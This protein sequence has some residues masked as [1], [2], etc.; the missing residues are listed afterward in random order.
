MRIL[1]SALLLLLLLSLTR[2]AAQN[3]KT[4]NAFAARLNLIDYGWLHDHNVRLGE[5]F[6]L[7]YY[8]NIAP[9]INVGLPLKL[10]L[11]RLPR[12]DNHT[13]TLSVDAIL[14]IQ[15]GSITARVLP[16]IYGGGSYFVESLNQSYVMLPL[17]AGFDIRVSKYAYLSLQG[18]Y[19]DTGVKD[20]DFVQG[21]AGFFFILHDPR[22]KRK[23]LRDSDRDGTPDVLDPCPTEAGPTAALGCPDVDNDS[24]ADRDDLCKT[25]AGPRA[26][27]GCP[28]SDGDGVADKQDDCP[29]L[30]GPLHGCPDSD[31]DGISDQKDKCPQESGPVANQGCPTD[32]D[33]D[34]DGLPDKQDRCPEL[35]GAPALRGCPDSDGDGVPNIDDDCPQQAGAV[36][37]CPDLDNDGVADRDDKCPS[38]AGPA[39]NQG[40]PEVKQETKE[41]LAYATKAV[42]FQTARATLKR[43]SFAIL[44]E[45]AGILQQYPDYKLVIS[46]HTDNVGDEQRNLELSQARAKACHDYLVSKGVAA[47]RLRY[48]GY[49]ETR[50]VGDNATAAGRELNRRVDFELVL[51]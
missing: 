20:R 37:G 7:A 9:W 24:I 23:R 33:S 38:S 44:D 31:G 18:E 12:T 30:A 8:R 14:K 27:G 41:R 2:L 6:E 32:R 29:T 1:L 16:F 19:R 22:P 49:G 50:P 45:L 47:D 13:V 3:P 4:P 46:G 26:T 35:P 34:L 36:K 25:L 15:P 21:G 28:D 48:A 51:E 10:G 39:S 11:A 17:G 40:C 43:E 5:G 42:Q